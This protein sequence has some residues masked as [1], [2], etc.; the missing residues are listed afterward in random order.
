MN[1]L[2]AKRRKQKRKARRHRRRREAKFAV[3][4]R[5]FKESMEDLVR[6]TSDSGQSMSQFVNGLDK[7]R[8][9]CIAMT[10]VTP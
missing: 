2:T 9:R 1:R 4:L 3:L 6:V 8:E 10:P 7:W 5:E